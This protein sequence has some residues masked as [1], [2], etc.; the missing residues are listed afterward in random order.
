MIVVILAGSDDAGLL[1]EKMDGSVRFYE[2][3][4]KIFMRHLA[5]EPGSLDE[6]EEGAKAERLEI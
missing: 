6:V 1:E 3:A 5:R 4:D 2:Y